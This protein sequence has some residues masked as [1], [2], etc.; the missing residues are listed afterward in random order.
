MSVVPVIT[1][2]GY[3][4]ITLESFIATLMSKGIEQVIDVRELPLSRRKGFSKTAISASLLNA[5][6]EYVHL[7]SLGDPKPGRLAARAGR[8]AEFRRIF[9]N[10][11]KTDEAQ[12]GLAQCAK[13]AKAKSSA[14]LCFERCPTCCHRAIIADSLRLA[15][16]FSIRHIEMLSAAHGPL[17]ARGSSSTRQG[18]SAS[19][20]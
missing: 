19:R 3:E 1:T 20:S 10:H 9:G 5:G 7:K 15:Y 18:R 4:G 11:L 16:G 14:L 8:D 12:L 2:I 13:L 17:T 6:I